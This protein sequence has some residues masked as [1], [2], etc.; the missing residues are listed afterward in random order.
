MTH[1]FDSPETDADWGELDA[2][3]EWD[4]LADEDYPPTPEETDDAS[5]APSLPIIFFSAACGIAG[6]VLVLFITLRWFELPVEFAAGFA[7]LGLLF[8]LGISGAALSAATGSRA[9]P[10]NILF[11]CG[12]I[13]LGILFLALCLLVGALIATLII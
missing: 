5:T 6:G 4:L 13:L 2:S 12:L 7:T 9:A 1:Q 10:A 11:S 3:D 8:A